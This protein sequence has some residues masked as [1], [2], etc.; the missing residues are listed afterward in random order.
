MLDPYLFPSVTYSIEGIIPSCCI[1]LKV[2]SVFQAC[3]P[4]TTCQ[5]A[6]PA[7]DDGQE[8][9]EDQKTYSLMLQETACANDARQRG[10][11]DAQDVPACPLLFTDRCSLPKAMGCP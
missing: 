8:D 6:E 9:G 3:R 4:A 11:C 10:P 2:S 1:M 7:E 5:Q